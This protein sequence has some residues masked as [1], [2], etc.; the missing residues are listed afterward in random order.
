[1][2]DILFRVLLCLWNHDVCVPTRLNLLSVVDFRTLQLLQ[3]TVYEN[4]G[5]TKGAEELLFRKVGTLGK[6]LIGYLWMHQPPQ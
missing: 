4:Q 5:T 1:M 6:D 3:G 2:R